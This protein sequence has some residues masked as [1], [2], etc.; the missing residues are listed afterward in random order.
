MYI[1][2]IA[3]A[4]GREAF[5]LYPNGPNSRDISLRTT[6]VVLHISEGNPIPTFHGVWLLTTASSAYEI[7]ISWGAETRLV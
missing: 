2:G 4:V 3:D 7:G 5:G 1:C 6:N